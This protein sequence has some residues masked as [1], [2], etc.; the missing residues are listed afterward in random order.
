MLRA[1]KQGKHATNVDAALVNEVAREVTEHDLG[2]DDATVRAALDPSTFVEAHDVPGGPAPPAMA[3]AIKKAR[4][5][6][7]EHAQRVS[8]LRE[9]LR[10]ASTERAD[11]VQQLTR[12]A[13]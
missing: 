12:Q 2:I 10:R 8:R 11:R 5:R 1:Y 7:E 13:S 9:N 6:L 4:T 3:Q